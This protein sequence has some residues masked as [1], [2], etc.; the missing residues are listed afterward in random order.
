MTLIRN[1]STIRYASVASFRRASR[2]TAVTFRETLQTSSH[3]ACYT[4]MTD[5][6]NIDYKPIPEGDVEKVLKLEQQSM[7]GL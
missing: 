7:H 5:R 6:S 4:E 3:T 1:D 2:V